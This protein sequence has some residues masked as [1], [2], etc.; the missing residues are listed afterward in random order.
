M[1]FADNQD[2]IREIHK[3]TVSVIMSCD[4]LDQV[5]AMQTYARLAIKRLKQFNLVNRREREV[6]YNIVTNI[7]FLSK[8]KHKLIKSGK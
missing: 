8:I 2:T 7:Q 3:K 4:S 5:S 6:M 1:S